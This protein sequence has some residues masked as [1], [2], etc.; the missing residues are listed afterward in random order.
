MVG[1]ENRE[2]FWRWGEKKEELTLIVKIRF[3][4]PFVKPKALL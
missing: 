4:I 1:R 3:D 2:V